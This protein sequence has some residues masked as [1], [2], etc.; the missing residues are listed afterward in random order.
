MLPLTLE[1]AHHQGG[2]RQVEYCDLQDSTVLLSLPIQ[3]LL[4]LPWPEWDV[5]SRTT[6]EMFLV[7]MWSI[8]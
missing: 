5:E 3:A 6:G 2:Q 4:I 7:E 1:L 8:L